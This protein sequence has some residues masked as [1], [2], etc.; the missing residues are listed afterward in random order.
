MILDSWF[1]YNS[2]KEII[3]VPKYLTCLHVFTRVALSLE[4]P[5][6]LCLLSAGI[7]GVYSHIWLSTYVF[8]TFCPSACNQI[9]GLKYVIPQTSCSICLALGKCCVDVVLCQCVYLL[10]SSHVRQRID[11]VWWRAT[12]PPFMFVIWLTRGRAFPVDKKQCLVLGIQ[13]VVF[14]SWTTGE[15]E[16]GGVAF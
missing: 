1:F 11:G 14:A 6:C 16:W 12:V 10:S 2:L 3:V 7:T 5:F 4:W 15:D 13:K 8:I 9:Q